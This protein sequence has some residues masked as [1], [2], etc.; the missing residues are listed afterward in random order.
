MKKLAWALLTLN[1][2]LFGLLYVETQ[3]RQVPT[4]LS[5]QEIHPE[6]LRLL[7]PE[8]LAAA[9]PRP[10]AKTVAP[11]EAPNAAA[12]DPLTACYSWGSFSQAGIA[13][14]RAALEKLTLTVDLR[15][16]S[17]EEA[18]RYW[19]YIPPAP[20]ARE[21]QAERDRLLGLGIEDI[22]VVQEP[23]WRN[24]ISLGIFKDS[25]L[26]DKRLQDLRHHGLKRA[27]KGVR[28]A[29]GSQS[30]F[31][32]K[33]VTAELAAQIEQLK[34]DFPGSELKKLNCQ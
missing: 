13:D 26:A 9:P 20:N 28:K 21:A 34:P 18:L 30:S 31:Y 15:P 19:V 25:S 17:A 11:A 27:V 14:A 1:I 12:P 10:P 16:T 4:P 23:R 24:A 7:T 33:D 32:L 6:Q 8:Q 2:A 22:F 5:S 29:E 3:Q